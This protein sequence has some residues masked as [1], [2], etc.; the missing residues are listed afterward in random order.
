MLLFGGGAMPT[1]DVHLRCE[2]T[3]LDFVYSIPAPILPGNRLLSVSASSRQDEDDLGLMAEFTDWTKQ[4]ISN[5]RD[6]CRT[7]LTASAGAI[8]IYF[9]LLKFIS[10]ERA[11]A[12]WQSM[13]VAPPV[14]LIGA[15]IAF[16]VALR[17]I[18]ALIRGP[19]AATFPSQNEPVQV[20]HGHPDNVVERGPLSLREFRTFREERL[21]RMDHLIKLGFA[22]FIAALMIATVLAIDILLTDPPR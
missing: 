12:G 15:M 3:G 14:L 5:G 16:T 6:F 10:I 11:S 13:S 2:T 20:H 9:A 17:P 1:S 19:R 21:I 22:A 4:S 8:P 18:P 7:M